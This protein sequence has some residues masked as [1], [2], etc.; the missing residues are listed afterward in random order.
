ML[1]LEV[2]EARVRSPYHS[3]FLSSDVRDLIG[4]VRELRESVFTDEEVALLQDWYGK[5][6]KDEM[7][8]SVR[9]EAEEFE[10]RK[11]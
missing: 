3:Q 9:E 4:E 10:R 5:N 2:I 7:I 1:D 11:R 6:W 8:S